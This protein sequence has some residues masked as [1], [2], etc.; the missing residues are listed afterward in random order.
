MLGTAAQAHAGFFEVGAAANYRYSGYDS[1]NYVQSLSYTATASYYFWEM[2]AWELDYTTGYSKQVSQGNGAGD[3]KEKVEDNIQL[4]SLDLVISF[5][6][7]QAAFKPYVKF[8]GGY[9]VKDRYMQVN[10]DNENLIA[11]QVGPRAEWWL[12]FVDLDREWLESQIRSRHLD[13]AA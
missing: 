4:T 10:D 5:A 11:H 1:N 13:F 6:D 2:C 3:P 12:W 9:L 7:R 8:G